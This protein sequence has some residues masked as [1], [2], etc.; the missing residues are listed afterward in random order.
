[1]TIYL[2]PN[3]LIVGCQKCGTTW[4][5]NALGNSKAIFVSVPKELNFFNKPQYKKNI[6]GYIQK[7]PDEGGHTLFLESTPHYFQ[8]PKNGHDT[9][10]AIYSTLKAPKIIV[11]FRNPIRRYE[12]AVIH[13]MMKGRIRYSPVIDDLIGEHL[14]LE[15]GF[16]GKI[17]DHWLQY[18]PEIGCFFYD[19]LVG[20]RFR[21]VS[22]VMKWLNVSNDLSQE[23]VE[24]RSNAKE[25][26]M[27]KLK[28]NWP[29]MPAL[30]SEVKHK[31]IDL[32]TND[33]AR[34]SRLTGKNLDTWLR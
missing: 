32:Y 34:L 16:Y 10:K 6:E 8:L 23:D 26:K 29:V 24:F 4:L 15:L 9:A 17:L 28:L 11:V 20:D 14:I 22:S 21:F 18:F 2:K 25:V 13:H 5:H 3:V 30:S 33:I 31:L 19:N 1:M 12:S 7:F 27:E